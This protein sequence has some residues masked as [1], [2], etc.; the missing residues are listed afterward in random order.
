MGRGHRRPGLRGKRHGRGPA[1][2]VTLPSGQGAVM[3]AAVRPK[4]ELLRPELVES[5][6]EEALA[7]LDSQGMFIE[8]EEALGLFAEAGMKVGRPARRVFIT[9]ALVRKC[10]A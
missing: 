1:G 8:N 6:V 9:P 3:S 2:P 4:L 5:I 10:L 7:V